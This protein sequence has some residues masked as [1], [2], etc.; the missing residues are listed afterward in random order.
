M[1][2]NGIS[3][4]HCGHLGLTFGRSYNLLYAFSWYNGFITVSLLDS[5][6]NS[7]W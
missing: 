5:N 3:I 4:N 2:T 7:K 1:K 6:G